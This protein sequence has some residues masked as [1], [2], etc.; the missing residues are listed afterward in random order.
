MCLAVSVTSHKGYYALRDN[1]YYA[2]MGHF[3][4]NTAAPGTVCTSYFQCCCDYTA[5]QL[6]QFLL[7][8]A[9]QTIQI[10]V[11]IVVLS[12]Q[13]ALSCVLN[14]PAYHGLQNT[15]RNGWAHQLLTNSPSTTPHPPNKHTNITTPL[16]ALKK[17]LFFFGI[18]L[19]S[20]SLMF[21]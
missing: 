21:R 9:I 12:G 11:T 1:A 16:L 7:S 18:S 19:F 17:N 20:G 13:H 3:Y 2:T 10:V 4:P 8:Y 6:F 5:A 15:F 14:F